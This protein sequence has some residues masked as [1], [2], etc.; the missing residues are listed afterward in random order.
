VST[1]LDNAVR[2]QEEHLSHATRDRLREAYE[3]GKTQ[4]EAKGYLIG[5]AYRGLATA[6]LGAYAGGLVVWL[7]MLPKA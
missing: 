5:W 7:C 4:G 1:P 3:A 6:L 2:Q